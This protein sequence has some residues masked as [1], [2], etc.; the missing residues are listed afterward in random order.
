MGLASSGGH[1]L[2]TGNIVFD[3]GTW[4]GTPTFSPP[5]G[6]YVGTQSVTISDATASPMIYYTTD[7]T[8]PAVQEI[9]S[10]P[11]LSGITGNLYVH[12]GPAPNN[13]ANNVFG[14]ISEQANP[15]TGNGAF[16]VNGWNASSVT[17]FAPNNPLTA[18]LSYA[19]SGTSSTAQAE[20]T[21]VGVYLQTIDLPGQ[22]VNSKMMITPQLNFAAGA[23]VI[24][25]DT[26]SVLSASMNI[27]VPTKSGGSNNFINV[28]H[29]FFM[30]SQPTIGFTLNA[31]I[32]GNNAAP[33]NI[34]ATQDVGFTNVFIV[35][36]P[37]GKP[38]SNPYLTSV[39]GVYTQSTFSALTQYSW[40][41]SWAQFAAALTLAQNT[42]GSSVATGVPSVV[43][44]DWTMTEMHVNAEMHYQSGVSDGTLGWSMTDWQVNTTDS[45]SI[46]LYSS[47][48]SVAASGTL[49]AIATSASI[50]PSFVGTAPYTIQVATP[51]I[52]PATGSYT[53]S[54]TVTIGDPTNGAAIFYTT[55]GSAPTA[56]PTGTTQT[57]S[58]Q[59]S[60]ASSGT[61]TIKAIA[62]KSGL[63]NSAI[64]SVNYTI[65]GGATP[66]GQ[67]TNLDTAFYGMTASG[68]GSSGN[69]PIPPNANTIA[70]KWT[71]AT[72]GSN[73][74]THNKIY[75]TIDGV[76]QAAITITAGTTYTDSA[77]TGCCGTTATP[78]NAQGQTWPAAHGYLYQVSAVDST[79]LEGPKSAFQI[80]TLYKNG[81]DPATGR[82]GFG[83]LNDVDNALTSNYNDTT[84]IGGNPFGSTHVILNT[85]SGT[86]GSQWLPN[87]GNNAPQWN[88][89]CGVGA[90]TNVFN[91]LNISL[92]PSHA[93][94]THN[95][96]IEYRTDTNTDPGGS[97][98][99]ISNVGNA[100][101]TY[102]PQLVVGQWST[103]KLPLNLLMVSTVADGSIVE[104][105]FYKLGCEDNL[106]INGNTYW[107]DNVFL[108]NS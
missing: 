95:F 23:E 89:W 14:L 51:I 12:G 33:N 76:L 64:A 83:I 66:P 45:S 40:T 39:A 53:G 68:Q 82:P 1:I 60:S 4:T 78:H 73:P 97:Q 6:S 56:P 103:F 8:R 19:A 106:R 13:P 50:R 52:T 63:A 21:Q 46:F 32:C 84:G 100:A 17:G 104:G 86:N 98:P 25:V 54:Q 105:M 44:S 55:D 42:F 87:M 10:Q 77:A 27:Q 58:G 29:Q 101:A 57:Y 74:I 65:S 20:G 108:S 72:Q 92:K 7:G 28:N 18:Q 49:N 16:Q 36:A 80:F 22:P 2:G 79:G 102:G 107:V 31:M 62:S 35:A 99:G 37:I 41:I 90:T 26:S 34:V 71:Q 61:Q 47:P 93:G 69:A 48:V 81:T 91:Y 70:I 9:L 43:P 88:I 24:W 3:I 15:Q 94:Q 5:A 59:F 85:T 75:R 11:S 67:V 38:V 96:W 30:V